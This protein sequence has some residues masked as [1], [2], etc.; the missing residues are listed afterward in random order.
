M[1]ISR[2][3]LV[4]D[5]PDIRKVGALCLR[6]I[7]KFEVLVASSAAEGLALAERELPDAIL[8]DVMMPGMD[9]PTMLLKLQSNALTARIPVVFLTAKVYPP[10]RDFYLN[11]GAVGVIPKPFDPMLLAQNLRL[12]VEGAS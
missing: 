4:D 5:E 6:A 1:G 11:L 10:D 8:L 12:A 2:V 3:L 9:G 7:G